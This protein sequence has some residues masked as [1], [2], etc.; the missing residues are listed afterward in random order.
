M[1]TITVEKETASSWPGIAQ[2]LD[3]IELMGW[4]SAPSQITVQSNEQED[5][6]LDSDKYFYI[7]ETKRLTVLHEFDMNRAYTIM[8]E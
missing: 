2:K 3:T 5:I 7:A 6:I 8:F 4:P 1:L